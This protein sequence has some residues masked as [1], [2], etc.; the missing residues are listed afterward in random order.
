MGNN[1][2]SVC[3]DKIVCSVTLKLL[4]PKNVLN[5]EEKE[6]NRKESKGVIVVEINGDGW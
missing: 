1:T 2:S 5:S 4:G 6:R 3:C